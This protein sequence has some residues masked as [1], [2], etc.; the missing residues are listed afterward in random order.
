M[1]EEGG[2]NGGPR[3]L[4]ITQQWCLSSAVAGASPRV[5]LVAELRAAIP[6]QP[7]AVSFPDL[8]LTLP[9]CISGT[10][11]GVQGFGPGHLCGFPSVLPASAWLLLS[12]SS[13][14]AFLQSQLTALLVRGFPRC[15]TLF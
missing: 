10:P 13:P 14:Q 5:F 1:R 2:C 11:W 6:S 15:E 9:L 4:H 12:S 3:A 7:T 8:L